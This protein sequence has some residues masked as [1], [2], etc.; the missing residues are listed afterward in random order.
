MINIWYNGKMKVLCAIIV[1]LLLASCSYY[2]ADESGVL[3]STL[4]SQATDV[5][6]KTSQ[7]P[8]LTPD[9]PP[10]PTPTPE[11]APFERKNVM[12]EPKIVIYKSARTLYVYD[13]ETLC[14][15]IE[16]ALG[17]S[18]EGHKQKEGDG[19]TP[20]GMYYI[21]MRN[22]KSKFYLSLGLSYPN[23]EDAEAGLDAGLIS[24]SEYDS[25]EKAISKGSRPPWD[26]ALG[27]EIMIHGFGTSSDWTAGCI[28]T[29]NGDMDYLWQNCPKGT[30]VE[31][32]P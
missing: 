12:D 14:A 20:E 3:E 27:G 25:I 15:K 17:F 22:G 2:A 18:P 28:A 31:I 1:L 26:T 24:Q 19:K 30:P 21:C 8:S 7:S 4:A 5:I 32:L 6:I 29:D 16:I 11:P 23:M 10:S 9:A 13:G